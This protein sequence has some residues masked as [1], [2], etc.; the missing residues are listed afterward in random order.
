MPYDFIVTLFLPSP[1]NHCKLGH[2][3]L[4]VVSNFATP[5]QECQ[6]PQESELNFLRRKCSTS[7]HLAWQHCHEF[8]FQIR[9]ANPENCATPSGSM[10]N[11]FTVWRDMFCIFVAWTI[12]YLAQRVAGKMEACTCPMPYAYNVSHSRR[13]FLILWKKTGQ[14][15]AMKHQSFTCLG[16]IHRHSLTAANKFPT[17]FLIG[18]AGFQSG[19]VGG[20]V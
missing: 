13:N 1:T 20:R 15:S 4:A 16:K 6:K 14:N 19:T 18:L 9:K 17:G 7:T 10:E 2:N 12:T 8:E 5:C 3:A 11:R